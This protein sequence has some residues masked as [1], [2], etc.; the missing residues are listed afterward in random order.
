MGIT[1][2]YEVPESVDSVPEMPAPRPKKII[3]NILCRVETE[4]SI[5]PVT[6]LCRQATEDSDD[7]S[8]EDDASDDRASFFIGRDVNR[9]VH[10][11]SARRHLMRGSVLSPRC[12]RVSRKISN[13]R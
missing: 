5:A 12:S 1:K 11:D 2:T 10:R 9:F 7:G 4:I 8:I 3:P 13:L 6:P